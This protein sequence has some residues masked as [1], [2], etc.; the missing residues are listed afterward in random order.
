MARPAHTRITFKGHFGTATAVNEEWSFSLLKGETEW[1]T[2]D[3]RKAV[4]DTCKT[5]WQTNLGPLHANFVV[6]DSVRVAEIDGLGRVKRN[7]DGSYR[8]S[9]STGAAILGS[10]ATSVTYPYQ[11]AVCVSLVTARAGATG[12]GR[13]FLPQTIHQVATTDARLTSANASAI[14][15]AAK[16]F[17]NAVQT[18]AGSNILVVS[19]KGYASNVTAVKVGRALDTMRSRRENLPEEYVQLAL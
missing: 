8:Q 1:A 7:A 6:L 9:D 5:A 14:A 16:A 13:F 3:G 11:T 12:K 4:A 15:T 10:G 19:S 2:E 17:V 18:A